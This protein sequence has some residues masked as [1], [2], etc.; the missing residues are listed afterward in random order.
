M[1]KKGAKASKP[2]SAL[3][4]ADSSASSSAEKE[5]AAKAEKQFNADKQTALDQGYT[6]EQSIKFATQEALAATTARKSAAKED[7]VQ[8]IVPPEEGI[9][10]P[11]SKL[12]KVTP[13]KGGGL[14]DQVVP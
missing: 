6:E 11:A 14:Y 3:A 13:K 2:D 4:S 12:A 7:I 10:A 8:D 9:S 5:L 1:A